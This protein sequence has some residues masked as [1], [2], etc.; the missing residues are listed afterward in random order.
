MGVDLPKGAG[1][2]CHI[3]HATWYVNEIP[4]QLPEVLS[5]THDMSWSFSLD[6]PNFW[7]RYEAP[8]FNSW[9]EHVLGQLTLFFLYLLNE[10]KVGNRLRND[11]NKRAFWNVNN[12]LDFTVETFAEPNMSKTR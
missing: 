1:M 9:T 12:I 2:F 10:A 6:D 11:D 4:A 8:S 7:D 3:P 5:Y